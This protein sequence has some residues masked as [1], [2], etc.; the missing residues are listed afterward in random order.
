MLMSGKNVLIIDP[1]LACVQNPGVCLCPGC[2]SYLQ[3]I[4][5]HG[6]DLFS[7]SQKTSSCFNF[8]EKC[9]ITFFIV[10]WNTEKKKGDLTQIGHSRQVRKLSANATNILLE[11]QGTASILSSYFST[12]LIFIIGLSFTA[13][14]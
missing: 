2:C 12:S 9:F 3:I 1:A 10:L 13:I 11:Y 6:Q 7:L 4:W 8:T 14:N 5:G